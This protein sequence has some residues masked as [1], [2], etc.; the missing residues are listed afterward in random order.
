MKIYQRQ[1]EKINAH[2]FF[3]FNEDKM[4]QICRLCEQKNTGN[5][6]VHLIAYHNDVLQKC[7]KEDMVEL[8]QANNGKLPMFKILKLKAFL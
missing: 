8:Y 6:F 7:L 4:C 1:L 3:T 2:Q 5:M